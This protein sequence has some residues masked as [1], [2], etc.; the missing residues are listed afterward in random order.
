MAFTVG[1]WRQIGQFA[2]S[3]NIQPG[4][5]NI[6]IS[7]NHSCLLSFIHT[8]KYSVA[9]FRDFPLETKYSVEMPRKYSV[10]T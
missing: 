9:D 6:I 5:K 1:Q 4:K 2:L 10:G 8:D 3:N 7:T